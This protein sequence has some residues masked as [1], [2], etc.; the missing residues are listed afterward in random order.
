[1]LHHESGMVSRWVERWAPLIAKGGRILD[2]AAGNGRHARWFAKRGHP[3]DAVDRDPVAMASLAEVAG[4]HPLC[5]DLENGVW[6]YERGRYAGVVVTNYLHRPLFPGLLGALDTGG[7]LLYETFAVGN[8][9][10]GRPSNPD[11]LLRA[12]ELLE[13]VQG[14]LRVVAY[15]DVYSDDPKPALLQRICAVKCPP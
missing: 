15:E 11:F 7:V 4:V 2:V 5:A 13:V 1:M 10:Y 9:R 8:E 3:V 14:N 6:P 12:G